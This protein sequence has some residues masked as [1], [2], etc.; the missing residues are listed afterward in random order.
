M[1][2]IYRATCKSCGHEFHVSE[3]GGMLFHILRC[4]RCASEK[5]MTFDEIG[6]PHLRYLKGLPGSYSTATGAHDEAARNTYQGEP[7]SES[8][9]RSAVEEMAG[10]CECGG[11]HRFDAPPRCAECRSLDIEKD[12]EPEILFD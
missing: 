8:E 5:S 6:D 12:P 7:I 2:S 1:G 4:D 11:S 9:Y 3:G 10:S